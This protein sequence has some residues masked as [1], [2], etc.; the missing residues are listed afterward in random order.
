MSECIDLTDA[1][2]EESARAS[3]MKMATHMNAQ[4]GLLQAHLAR[5]KPPLAK[6]GHDQAGPR[7][8][9][10][11]K[12]PHDEDDDQIDL[13]SSD[14]DEDKGARWTQLNKKRANNQQKEEEQER[15]GGG[16]V[17]RRVPPPPISL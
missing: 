16:Q 12:R 14:E 10:T 3:I 4:N 13:V 6:R 5:I 11:A 2:E 15:G 9:P 7:P 1:A 8:P 17:T